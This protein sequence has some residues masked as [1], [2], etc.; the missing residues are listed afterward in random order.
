M[1]LIIIGLGYVGTHICTALSMSPSV[2]S[3][4]GTHRTSPVVPSSGTGEP[5]LF[6][7]TTPLDKDI[8]EGATHI[9]VTAPPENGV[10][11]FFNLHGDHLA[12]LRG[13]KWI[14]YMSTTSV[15]GDHRGSW[16]NEESV[17]KPTS[18]QGRDRL[19]AE[20]DRKSVV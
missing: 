5:C 12:L 18:A 2:H 8:L 10:D 6:N 16:V 14:G 9:L 7:A 17:C 20:E 3:I 13:L 19:A 4:R 15:Y 1:N 11:T